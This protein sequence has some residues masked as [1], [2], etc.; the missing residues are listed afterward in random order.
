MDTKQ[1]LLDITAKYAELVV[2]VRKLIATKVEDT[3]TISQIQTEL[4]AKN[5]EVSNLLNANAETA[6]IATGLSND[7][8]SLI[9]EA[10]NAIPAEP[11][12]EVPAPEVPVEPTPEAPEAPEVSV[13][14]I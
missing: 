6:A 2:L 5:Q 1:I 7:I 14:E 3:E 12:P 9:V 8:A 4:N 13:E 10:T 11:T